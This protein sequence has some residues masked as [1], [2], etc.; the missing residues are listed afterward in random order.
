M[1]NSDINRNKKNY[2]RKGIKEETGHKEVNLLRASS[3]W[4]A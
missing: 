2:N 1:A 3:Y 4:T